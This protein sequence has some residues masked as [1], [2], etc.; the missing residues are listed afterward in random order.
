M[1]AA[2][3]GAAH[4]ASVDSAEYDVSVSVLT[5]TLDEPAFPIDAAH[6][7]LTGG[8]GGTVVVSQGSVSHAN[9][10]A[11]VSIDPLRPVGR[12]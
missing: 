8:Q 4:A 2:T 5:V 1:V 9:N 10:T 12:L 11:T 7:T 3:G 6:V